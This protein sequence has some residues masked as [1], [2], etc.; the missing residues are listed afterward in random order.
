[1]SSLSNDDLST[2]MR[3]FV[4]EQLRPY[5]GNLVHAVHIVECGWLPEVDSPQVQHHLQTLRQHL[6]KVGRPENDEFLLR[7]GLTAP[8][9]QR[10]IVPPIIVL[11]ENRGG[12]SARRLR[13]AEG[14]IERL[15]EALALGRF[16][17]PVLNS[18]THQA[19]LELERSISAQSAPKDVDWLRWIG[20]LTSDQVDRLAEQGIELLSSRTKPVYEIGE[21]IIEQLVC[22]Q[23]RPI[24]EVHCRS[25]IRLGIF[26]PS[27][28]FR[29]CGESLARELLSRIEAAPA[30]GELGH[31]L[32]ALAWTRSDVAR[33][34]FHQWSLDPPGWTSALRVPPSDYLHDAGWCLDSDGRSREL[35][36]QSCRRLLLTGKP[37]SRAVACRVSIDEQCPSCEGPLSWLFDFSSISNNLF[38]GELADAPRRVLSCLHCSCWGPTFA[39]YQPDG[40]SQW[41][42][43]IEPREYKF[44]GASEASSRRLDESECPRFVC[45]MRWGLEDASSFGG[46]PMW[47]QDVEYPRCIECG[48]FMTFLAQHDNSGLGEEG[49]YYAFFCSPCHVTGV[50]YQQT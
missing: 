48:Q 46:L 40:D 24:G 18:D 19:L 23:P 3:A 17:F 26:R 9:T 34:A 29:E 22:F 20:Q 5:Q 13:E 7:L 11:D 41:L 21:R 44:A 25:L 1:V 27:C 32:S 14:Q 2:L 39:K 37:T 43:P 42:A 4:A 16:F 45:A 38:S 31:V 50:T 10:G 6:T 12:F 30:P 33:L 35:I 36:G 47:L 8:G 49:I 15:R 28:V